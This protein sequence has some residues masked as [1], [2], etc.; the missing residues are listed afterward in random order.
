MEKMTRPNCS[1][2]DASIDDPEHTFFHCEKW[3]LE[4]RNFK[5]TFG[6]SIVECF[7]DVILNSEENCYSLTSYTEA[8]LKSKKFD[9]DERS[10]MHV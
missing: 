4:R 5:A 9:L 10:R 8:L 1:Y 6:V 3:R 7:Y 2:D